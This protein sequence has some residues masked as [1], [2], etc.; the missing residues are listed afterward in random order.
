MLNLQP[1]P[2]LFFETKY[3]LYDSSGLVGM[4]VCRYRFPDGGMGGI[5]ELNFVFYIVSD[6]R[7]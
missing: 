3:H 4:F 6:L 1:L 7:K 5:L 2:F